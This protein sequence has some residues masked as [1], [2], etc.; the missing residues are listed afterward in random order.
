MS[1]PSPATSG[2]LDLPPMGFKVFQALDGE[3]VFGTSPDR[4]CPG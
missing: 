4:P 3:R 1:R 2:V